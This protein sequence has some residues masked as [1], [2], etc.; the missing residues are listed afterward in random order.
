MKGAVLFSLMCVAAGAVVR[1]AEVL[2]PRG[3]PLSKASFYDP[4]RDF[5]CLDGSGTIPFS[6]VND[7]Y[8]DCQDGSDEPGTAA[9]PN[10]FFHCT[11]AGHSPLTLPSSRVNDGVCDCC[12]AS[13]EYASSANCV[14]VCRELGRAAREEAVKRR[15][16]RLRGFQ[17]RQAMIE[18]G[19]KRKK[20]AEGKIEDLKKEKEEA[21]T[22]RIEKEELKKAAEEPEKEALEKYRAAESEKKA[23]EIA[24]QK[25]KDEAEAREAFAH[26]DND[27]DGVLTKE[28]MMSRQTFDTNRDGQVS[29]EEAKFY[30]QQEDTMSLETFISTGWAMMRPVY[31]MDKRMFTPP[32][33][34]PPP[35]AEEELTPPPPVFDEEDAYMT[36]DEEDEEE[37]E[38]EVENFDS[39]V[40]S[41]DDGGDDAEDYDL[42][43]EYAEGDSKE[44]DDEEDEG[45]VPK[46]EEED[47]KYD[48]ETQKIVDAAN[49]AR[50]HFDEA[51]RRVRDLTRE[52]R[53]L[54][55]TQGKDYGP[56]E[57]FR[58]LEGNCY[59]FT[60]REYIYRLCPFDKATQK[61]K[62]GHGETRLGQWGEWTGPEG[63]K[64]SRML[65]SN[66]QACWNGPTRSADVHIS[67]GTEN[68]LIGVSEPNRC[69]YVFL[70]STPAVCTK[71]E[72]ELSEET[73]HAHTEL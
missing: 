19:H 56:E 52:L 26:L 46:E 37:E 41:E 64:Y 4:S 49:E 13:D 48:E 12:D 60:D 20:E 55:E 28:E 10:G 7:D 36:D 30:L 17:L 73:T 8:C 44:D 33:T 69:E 68:K 3:V 59:D 38:E 61:P 29:E 43:D 32:S 34:T 66:G 45:D 35:Q 5:S 70:F 53:T 27:G 72:E 22:V 63:D 65:Y 11:N 71:P 47:P 25:E 2:R 6:Y 23:Q 51:D 50:E 24:Q 18:D 39:D 14:D 40:D 42:P 1:A 31:L 16:E 9:C 58:V 21:D 15:E 54:E 57:E 62:S 67:C